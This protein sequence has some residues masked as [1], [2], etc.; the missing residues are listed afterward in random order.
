MTDDTVQIDPASPMRLAEALDRYRSEGPIDDAASREEWQDIAALDVV[1][2][3]E[4]S[5]R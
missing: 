3:D 1:E 5:G 4:A 2:T